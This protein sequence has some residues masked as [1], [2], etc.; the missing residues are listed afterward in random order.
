M[1]LQQQTQ[2]PW[3]GDVAIKVVSTKTKDFEMKIRI[4]GWVRN[5]VVPSDLYT[6]NDNEQTGYSVEVNGEKMESKIEKGYFS[7]KRKWKK[8]DVV[9]VHFDMKPRTVT[10]NAKVRDDRGRVAIER[11]PLVY[12]AEEADHLGMDVHHFFLGEQPRMKVE[13]KEI[14]NTEGDNRVF[15]VQSVVVENAQLME[16]DSQGRLS[17]KNVPLRLIPYFAW[18]H[19]GAGKMDVWFASSLDVLN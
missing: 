2:Y 1:V 6:F 5:E 8:G 13:E 10:A 3:E 4:P 18:N 17:V 11:G 9:K 19:R 16:T 12:C 15:K 7:L 14:K